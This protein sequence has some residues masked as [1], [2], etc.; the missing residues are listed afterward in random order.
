MGR[1]GRVADGEGAAGSDDRS[2]GGETPASGAIDAEPFEIGGTVATTSLCAGD[3]G[4][5][6]SKPTGGR[7]SAAASTIALRSSLAERDGNANVAGL[8]S[9]AGDVGIAGDEG[10]AGEEGIAEFNEP[11]GAV[12]TGAPSGPR[13]RVQ[14][15]ELSI[16]A[17]LLFWLGIVVV[18]PTSVLVMADSLGSPP[19]ST[20]SVG[21]PSV[22]ASATDLG[23]EGGGVFT[24]T[25]T[26]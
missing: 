18:E 22:I 17:E 5:P 7:G 14:G 25:Y 15:L 21:S 26:P 11:L 6:R 24:T 23:M 1:D 12:A 8:P 10:I 3:V 4:S 20:V 13:S 19:S 9:E 16:G 2:T